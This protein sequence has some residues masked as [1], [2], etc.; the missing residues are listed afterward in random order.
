M[1]D[2]SRTPA[3]LHLA[4]DFTLFVEMVRAGTLPQ[5]GGVRK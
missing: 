5:L 2:D 1:L 3:A 4:G